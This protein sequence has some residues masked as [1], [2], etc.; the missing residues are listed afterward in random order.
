MEKNFRKIC[1]NNHEDFQ[2]FFGYEEEPDSIFVKL[3]CGHNIESK[4]LDYSFELR[5]EDKK[6]IEL[7]KFE[8]PKCKSIINNPVRYQKY[9]KKI[10]F[11]FQQAKKI[12]LENIKKVHEENLKKLEKIEKIQEKYNELV[13]QKSARK[14]IPKNFKLI[15]AKEYSEN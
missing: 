5:D 6:E 10:N 3:D 8:C 15:K 9:I 13:K 12:I 1:D 7:K 4:S 2:I 11:Q 14:E